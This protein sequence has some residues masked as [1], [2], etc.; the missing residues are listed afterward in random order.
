MRFTR[1]ALNQMRA[2]RWSQQQVVDLLSSDDGWIS[3]T[4]RGKIKAVGVIDGERAVVVLA[5][6]AL[7]LVVTDHGER[8]RM[9]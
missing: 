5:T 8:G 7:D 1:H 2:K 4:S 6:D 9:R 3:I